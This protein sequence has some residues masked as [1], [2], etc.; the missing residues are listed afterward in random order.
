MSDQSLTD[1]AERMFSRL[2]ELPRL[3]RRRLIVRLVGLIDEEIAAGAV[4]EA[5]ITSRVVK[6]VREDEGFGISP[7]LVIILGELVAWLV[8]RILDRLFPK[9]GNHGRDAAQPSV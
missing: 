9:E 6:R 3:G 1:E 7:I 8:R 4:D 2:S 5:E